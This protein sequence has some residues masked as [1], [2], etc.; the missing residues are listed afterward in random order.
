MQPKSEANKKRNT[1]SGLFQIASEKAV[2]HA[3]KIRNPSVWLNPS[4]L[5]L[6]PALRGTRTGVENLR[7]LKP[8]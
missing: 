5:K 1:K 2:F 7:G 4:V 6:L 8:Q 3:S